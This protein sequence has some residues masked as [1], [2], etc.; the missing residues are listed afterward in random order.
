MKL[1]V[2]R[3]DVWSASIEDKPGM[4]AQKLETL[5]EAG[6]D[7]EFVIARRSHEKPGTG[8]VF[9]T[10]IK[11]AKQVKAGRS[12]GFEKTNSLHSLRILV[13]DKPGVGAQLTKQIA[14]AGI[15][16]RGFSGAAIGG[17]AVFHLAFESQEDANNAMRCVKKLSTR[18]G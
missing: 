9:V 14:E 11:G 8:V 15:N 12:A 18:R 1:D 2:T 4:L 13:S 10:P 7:L 5:S 6:A 3:V 16:L 17:R